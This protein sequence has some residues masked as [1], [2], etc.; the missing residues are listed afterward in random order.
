[1]SISAHSLSEAPLAA[2]SA[3]QAT[4][5]RKPPPKRSIVA[6]ADSSELPEPR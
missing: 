1:M 4:T 3:A 5:V 6:K 2:H